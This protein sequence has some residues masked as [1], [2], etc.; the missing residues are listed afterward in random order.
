MTSQPV[1]GIHLFLNQANELPTPGG[2]LHVNWGRS[3][4]ER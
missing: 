1:E 4:V 3:T 2:Y